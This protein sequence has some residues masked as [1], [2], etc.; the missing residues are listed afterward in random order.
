MSN[1]ATELKM[2]KQRRSYV[3]VHFNT[4]RF[5]PESLHY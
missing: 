4:E 3:P 5:V 2:E 1:N